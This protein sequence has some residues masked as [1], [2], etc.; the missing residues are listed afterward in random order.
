MLRA[1]AAY[2]QNGTVGFNNVHD[3]VSNKPFELCRIAGGFELCSTLNQFGLNGTVVFRDEPD[4]SS[5]RNP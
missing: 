2:K 3:P 4:N 5:V 1:A